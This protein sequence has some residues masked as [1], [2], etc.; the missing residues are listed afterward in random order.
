MATA[1]NKISDKLNEIF[2]LG[3]GLAF[4][5]IKNKYIKNIVC[6]LPTEYDQP[7]VKIKRRKA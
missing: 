3:K 7:E 2:I 1:K 6:N 5:S 4:S